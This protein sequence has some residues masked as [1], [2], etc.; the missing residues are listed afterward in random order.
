MADYMDHIIDASGYW[1][2]G[3]PKEVVEHHEGD[4]DDFADIQ[5]DRIEV[6]KECGA[7]QDT[8]AVEGAK[9]E[10]EGEAEQAEPSSKQSSSKAASA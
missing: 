5:A 2:D 6:L 10:Q 4:T 3:R 7:I 9:K 8:A 1:P